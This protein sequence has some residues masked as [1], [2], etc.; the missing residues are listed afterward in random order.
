MNEIY[1][2]TILGCERCFV[3]LGM[4]DKV[5]CKHVCG[6][7]N[8]QGES[9]YIGINDNGEVVGVA[10]CKNLVKKTGFQCVKVS[11]IQKLFFNNNS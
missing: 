2:R 7:A 5:D 6:F 3:A 10:D 9:I 1:G 4:S 8:A 11:L